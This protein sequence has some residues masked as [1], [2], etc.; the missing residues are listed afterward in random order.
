MKIDFNTNVSKPMI[1]KNVQNPLYH[2]YQN[3]YY[4]QNFSQKDSAKKTD[5]Q[6]KIKL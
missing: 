4:Q 6:I 2:I 1:F 3:D 5:S